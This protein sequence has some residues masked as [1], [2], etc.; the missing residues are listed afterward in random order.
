MTAIIVSDT[1]PIRALA[2]LECVPWL[3]QVFDGAE[4]VVPTAVAGELEQPPAD[5]P[6]VD[7]SVWP[8]FSIRAPAG[9]ERVAEL[10]ATLD[11]GE[12]QA[13]VL[14]EEIGAGAVLIDELAGREVAVE[15]GLTVVGT[16]GILLRAK[17]IGLCPELRP[18]LDRLQREIRFFVSPRLR[19]QVLNQAGESDG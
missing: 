15:H 11:L 4:I 16:L 7:L 2:H 1:S 8:F 10:Q 18:L 3:Q 17:R 12:A 6:V 19:R 14:A 5:L 13:I 9:A